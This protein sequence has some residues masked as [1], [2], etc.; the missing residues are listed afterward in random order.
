MATTMADERTKV[1]NTQVST[2]HREALD[3]IMAAT[4]PAPTLRAMVEYLIEQEAER[5]GIKIDQE[6]DGQQ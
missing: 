5:L 1:V 3:R 6:K 2:A 4:R